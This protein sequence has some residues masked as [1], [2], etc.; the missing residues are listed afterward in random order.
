MRV[1]ILTAVTTFF[2]GMLLRRYVPP[3]LFGKEA[4]D[5]LRPKT[6]AEKTDDIA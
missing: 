6:L 2:V 3:D 4:A 5:P 1:V